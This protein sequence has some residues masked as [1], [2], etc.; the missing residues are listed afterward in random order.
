MNLEVD[1]PHHPDSLLNRLGLMASPPRVL[2][3]LLLMLCLLLALSAIYRTL[4][5]SEIGMVRFIIN[6][7]A[8]ILDEKA[9]EELSGDLQKRLAGFELEIEQ[10]MQSWQDDALAEIEANFHTASEHYLDWYFSFTGS[11][12]RLFIAVNGDLEP[13]METQLEQRLIQS[14]GLE[15]SLLDLREEYAVRLVESE[16]TWLNETLTHLQGRYTTADVQMNEADASQLKTVNFDQLINSAWQDQ[17]LIPRWSVALV[18]GGGF[19]ALSNIIIAK[20]VAASPTFKAGKAVVSRFVTR[21]GLHATRSV[22]TGGMAAVATSPSG[23]G[24]LLAGAAAVSS[25]LAI[26]AGSE[27]VLLKAEEALQ[28]P[29]MEAELHSTWEEL[30]LEVK[31]LL[32]AEKQVRTEALIENIKRHETQTVL[33]SELPKTYR[34]FG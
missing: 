28:R 8:L 25:T 14:S 34:I 1:T 31:G 21:M 5:Q 33:D 3:A 18:G 17:L 20:R 26:A 7:E 10:Q 4:M 27:F 9:Q 24:A 23:L 6:G 22:A 32:Q 12:T 15:S 11:Y 29:E 13:W 30:E 19:G 2:L 16:Q